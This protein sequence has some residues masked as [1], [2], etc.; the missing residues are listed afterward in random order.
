MTPCKQAIGQFDNLELMKEATEHD[1]ENVWEICKSVSESNFNSIQQFK[2]AF[3]DLQSLRTKRV[4]NELQATL[5]RMLQNAYLSKEDN[6]K[7]CFIATSHLL[8]DHVPLSES[9]HEVSG[10]YSSGRPPPSIYEK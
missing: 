7:V 5:K 4:S 9:V 10:P 1:F 8:T 6:Y 2:G 3:H